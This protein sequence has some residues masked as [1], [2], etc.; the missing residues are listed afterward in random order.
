MNS[1]F[2]R[3][4]LVF[5]CVIVCV[6]AFGQPEVTDS[7]E[8]QVEEEEEEKELRYSFISENRYETIH[9][10]DNQHFIPEKYQLGQKE[11]VPIEAG[12]MVISILN[13]MIV[14]R[15]VEG[16]ATFHITQKTK[17]RVG[18]VYELMSKEGK[19]ARFKVV[20]NQD[21]YITLLY[22]YSRALGEHTFFLAEK[23]DGA[24]AAEQRFF[25]PKS[26]IFVRF[27]ANLL[28]K[29][30]KPYSVVKDMEVSNQPERVLVESPLSLSFNEYTCNT[31]QGSFSIKEAKTY[32][33]RSREFP[34]V[35]SRIELF[36]KEKPK[37]VY[38][39]LSFKQEIEC[40]EIGNTRYF[41][42]P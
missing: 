33:Y 31:P 26:Q 11:I 1:N 4:L 37:R 21:E 2:I 8:V 3:F 6:P 22:F 39:Y 42:M 25:T 34:S 17:E 16:L 35:R 24:I 32:E 30:I 19:V 7:D 38:I 18:Y 5:A 41:L 15:G 29:E 27:Y 28:E 10:L 13:G 36:V 23:E 9:E 20:L 14:I 40:I 12:E